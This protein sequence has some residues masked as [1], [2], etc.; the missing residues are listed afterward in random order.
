MNKVKQATQNLAALKDLPE[1]DEAIRTEITQIE[2]S[3]EFATARNNSLMEM[4]S[5][6][7][8]E[9]LLYRF[10]LCFA[11]QFFQ[12]MCGGN[13]IS[14]CKQSQRPII[15]LQRCLE[16]VQ[17]S[18]RLLKVCSCISKKANTFLLTRRIDNLPTKPRTRHEP[19]EDPS[20]MRAHM[21][22][23]MLFLGLLCH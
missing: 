1:D 15:I 11:L 14:V 10:C 6:D 21:E 7:D 22:V 23:P 18:L 2:S 5:K 9:R 12:Q 13:F 20:I 19:L 8:D 16:E 3:L 4:F 17:L